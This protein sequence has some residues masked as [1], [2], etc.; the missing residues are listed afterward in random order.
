MVVA[1]L[2][3]RHQF[4]ALLHSFPAELKAAVAALK[5]PKS[6]AA[7][8]RQ[9]LYCFENI[10]PIC[11]YYFD[12]YYPDG[13]T[14][15][16]QEEINSILVRTGQC[17]NAGEKTE[18]RV[19][20]LIAAIY[21]DMCHLLTNADHRVNSQMM[22]DLQ[23]CL[24]VLQRTAAADQN[25]VLCTPS[26]AATKKTQVLNTFIQFHTIR[27]E[28]IAKLDW[29]HVRY[30][31]VELGEKKRLS[32]RTLLGQT[33]APTAFKPVPSENLVGVQIR[34]EKART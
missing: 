7:N 19:Q 28:D 3:H 25:F 20:S 33:A 34:E 11:L 15:E 10:V 18:N 13:M 4:W 29:T 26:D 8:R 1:G 31:P 30:L 5:K 2:E 24:Y 9:L 22:A 17:A 23:N 16:L 21:T 27:A 12:C 6:F 32:C 14:V